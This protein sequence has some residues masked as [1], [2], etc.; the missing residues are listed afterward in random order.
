MDGGWAGSIEGAIAF[1]LVVLTVLMFGYL[2]YYYVFGRMFAPR[3]TVQARIARKFDRSNTLIDSEYESYGYGGHYLQERIWEAA[4][5]LLSRITKRPISGIIQ[6]TSCFLEIDAE[7]K[8]TEYAV[9]MEVYGSVSEGDEGWLTHKGN[10]LI[11]FRTTS[12]S[13]PDLR[14]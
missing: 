3:R 2:A 4:A 5:D 7:G 10:K 12:S 8:R 13:R 9:S 11:K 6:E 1:V 14:V